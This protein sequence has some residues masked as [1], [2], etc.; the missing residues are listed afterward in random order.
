MDALLR[1]PEYASCPR[2]GEYH[3]EALRR[4]GLCANCAYVDPAKGRGPC[5]VCGGS[6]LPLQDHHIAGR[7]KSDVT[8]PI[9]LNCHSVLSRRQRHNEQDSETKALLYGALAMA[10]LWWERL[11]GEQKQARIQW[12]VDKFF[13]LVSK[14]NSSFEIRLGAR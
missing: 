5:L 2:C 8:V 12:L 7:R 3:I 4:G 6:D 10:L 14:L 11:D 1:L 13:V 9:C